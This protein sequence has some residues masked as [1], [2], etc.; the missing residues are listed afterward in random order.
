MLAEFNTILENHTE[1]DQ[2]SGWLFLDNVWVAQ[3]QI[4]VLQRN[5]VASQARCYQSLSL[6]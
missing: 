2:D 1:R 4:R 5:L 6:I 3:V